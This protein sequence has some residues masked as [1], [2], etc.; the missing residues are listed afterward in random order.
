MACSVKEDLEHV[1]KNLGA[2]LNEGST[3]EEEVGDW[4]VMVIALA[5]EVHLKEEVRAF[6]S[7]FHRQH[8]LQSP[9][10]DDP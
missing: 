9:L 6:L 1:Q 7:R 2:S 5:E 4:L 8:A 10:H 3:H